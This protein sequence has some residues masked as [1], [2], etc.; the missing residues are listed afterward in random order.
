[1]FFRRLTPTAKAEKLAPA[2][3]AG[4]SEIAERVLSDLQQGHQIQISTE[5]GLQF[6]IEMLVFC[7]HLVDRAAFANFRGPGRNPHRS[8]TVCGEWCYDFGDEPPKGLVVLCGPRLRCSTV[9]I[10]ACP[11]GPCTKQLVK[12]EHS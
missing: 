9:R 2:L 11:R 5:S 4:A 1:M 12:E 7:I 10:D 6:R 8:S 3:L